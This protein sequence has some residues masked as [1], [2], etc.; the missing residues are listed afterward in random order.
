MSITIYNGYKLPAMNAMEL[1]AFIIRFRELAEQ[2]ASQLCAKSLA[3][4]I[5]H[6]LDELVVFG[7]EEFIKR[8]LKRKNVTDENADKKFRYCSTSLH[9]HMDMRDRYFEIQ[10]TSQRDPAMDFDCHAVFIP[11]EDKTLVLFYAELEEMRELWKSQ[12]EVSSYGYWNNTDYPED[13]TGEEWEERKK[14]WMYDVE[15]DD[16]KPKEAG[17][18]IVFVKG[19][20]ERHEIKF[21]DIIANMSSLEERAKYVAWNKLFND[22]FLEFRKEDAE[23]DWLDTDRKVSRW[24]RSDEGKTELQNQIELCKNKM[25]PEFTVQHLGKSYQEISM[26][27]SEKQD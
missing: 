3:N 18:E 16:K 27:L 24:L 1:N 26:Q 22:K 11:L 20:P 12:K 19:L 23:E 6:D 14:V 25:I 4:L 7:K 5:S 21:K 9:A 10:R 15:L 2:K 8:N 17:M 13:V